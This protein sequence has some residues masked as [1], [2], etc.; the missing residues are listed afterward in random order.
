MATGREANKEVSDQLDISY[1]MDLMDVETKTF[2]LK[3]VM[4]LTS[5]SL[6]RWGVGGCSI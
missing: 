3:N 6:S 2:M 4:F 1:M 5:K